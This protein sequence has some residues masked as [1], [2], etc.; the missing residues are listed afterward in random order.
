[1]PQNLQGF[2]FKFKR[3]LFH[4]RQN[5]F[6]LDSKDLVVIDFYCVETIFLSIF[7]NHIS[8]YFSLKLQ[9]GMKMTIYLPEKGS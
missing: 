6:H 7:E 5:S 3:F 1:M 2:L 8:F 9:L 4:Y